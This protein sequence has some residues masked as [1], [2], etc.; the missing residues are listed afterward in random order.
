MHKQSKNWSGVQYP[1]NIPKSHLAPQP[2]TGLTGC[3]PQTVTFHHY[4]VIQHGVLGE[5]TGLL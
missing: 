3:Y 1:L 2:R 5:L 4:I